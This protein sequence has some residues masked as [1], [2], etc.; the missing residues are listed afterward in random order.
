M[1]LLLDT[2]LLLW[3]LGNTP[4]LGKEAK[5]LI[6]DSGNTIFVSTVTL[7]EMWLKVSVGKLR[8]PS[9]IEARIREEGFELLPLSAAHARRV[10]TLPWHHRDPFDRMLVSQA[11]EERL[12]LLTA[13][14]SMNAYGE[15][16]RVVR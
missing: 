13:D 2:H 15:M 7:W 1:R 14:S 8:I 12:V 9:D 5:R 6:A 3:W 11:E 4:E 16:V 10:A